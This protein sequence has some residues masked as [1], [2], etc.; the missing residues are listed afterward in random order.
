MVTST[1]TVINIHAYA[2]G[3]CTGT[4]DPLIR[5]HNIRVER[6]SDFKLV[7]TDQVILADETIDSHE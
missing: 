5:Q 6:P 1:G 4:L 7:F 3:L 2:D